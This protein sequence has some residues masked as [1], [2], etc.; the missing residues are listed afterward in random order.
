MLANPTSTS[1]ADAARRNRV[2][3]RIVEYNTVLSN[4]CTAYAQCRYDRGTGF[5]YRFDASEVS[6]NDYFHPNVAGQSD[7][8]HRVGRDLGLLTRLP[9]DR[10]LDAPSS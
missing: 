6:T 10:R 5:S 7:R 9:A 1:T 3:R 4:A 2:L 8:E